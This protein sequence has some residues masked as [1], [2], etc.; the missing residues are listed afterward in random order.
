MNDPPTALVGFGSPTLPPCRPSMNDPPTAL[1]G[2]SRTHGEC[3]RFSFFSSLLGR[4]SPCC[5]AS[6]MYSLLQHAVFHHHATHTQA[7]SA[8]TFD[9]DLLT[10]FESGNGGPLRVRKVTTQVRK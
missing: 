5:S 3:G 4:F 9:N 7:P 8:N 6:L 2:L 1:V 10:R